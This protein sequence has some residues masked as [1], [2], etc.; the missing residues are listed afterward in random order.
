[1]CTRHSFI[2]WQVE[3]GKSYAAVARYCGTSPDV[4]RR[5]YE[6]YTLPTQD[7]E[8]DDGLSLP[9]LSAVNES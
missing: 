8:W 7:E 5:H 9:S 2:S 4:I 6:R 1:M 3:A